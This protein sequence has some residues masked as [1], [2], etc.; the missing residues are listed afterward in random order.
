MLGHITANI[1]PD[2]AELRIAS[3]HLGP[4][5]DSALRAI[6]RLDAT[7]A[8]I[9]GPIAAIL[10]RT[11]SVASSKIEG[12]SASTDDYARGLHGFR[13]NPTAVAMASSTTATRRLIDSV[14]TNGVITEADILAAHA[15]LME[16]DRSERDYAGRWR[17]LQNWIG[18]SEY[19]PLGLYIFHRP[20]NLSC[21]RWPT[22]WRFADEMT[23][24][25]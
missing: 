14:K 10:L 21:R 5:L 20:L 19:S 8:D 6:T 11:E 9:L 4:S 25:R 23:S 17:D 12:I 2:I 3:E 18:G 22:C 16:A 1:P 24:I 13:G 7:S 15:A